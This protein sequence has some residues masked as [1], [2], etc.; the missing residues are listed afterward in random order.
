MNS[1]KPLPKVCGFLSSLFSL[2]EG[3]V[4]LFLEANNFQGIDFLREVR[5]DLK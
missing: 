5:L 3:V 4:R 2:M 1:R